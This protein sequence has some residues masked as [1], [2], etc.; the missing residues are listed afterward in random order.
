MEETIKFRCKKCDGHM[1]PI[2]YHSFHG[3]LY[4]WDKYKKLD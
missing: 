2:K 1:I 4:T 3:I